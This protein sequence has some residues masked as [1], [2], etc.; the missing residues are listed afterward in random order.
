MN[1]C[2]VAL[3]GC[4]TVGLG[5]AE[6]L[7]GR[8]GAL[9]QRLGSGVELKYIIDVRLEELRSELEP[10]GG[11]MLTDDLQ[12]PLSDSDVDVVVE[13]FGGKDIAREVVEDALKAGKDV[14]TA[15]KALLAAHGAELYQLA[16]DKGGSIAFEASV[17]GGIP[18]VGAMGE[19]LVS[20]RVESVHGIVNGTC[21]YIL[22]RMTEQGMSFEDAL[23]E[24]QEKGY[25]EADP[26]LD[27]EG[28]DSAHKLAVLARLA[29]GIDVGEE[30]IYCEGLTEVE[31]EDICYARSLGYTV[32]LLAIGISRAGR[33]ELR[34]HPAL[35]PHEHPLAAV[36]GARNAVCVRG[37][38]VGE[39]VLTGLGAG[40]WPTASAVVGDIS[41][42]ALGT[43]QRQFA[44]LSQFGDVPAAEVLPRGEVET[45]YYF[46][47]SCDDR[48]GV[49]AQVA[50]ILGEHEI[51]IASCIQQGQTPDESGRVPVVFLSHRAR[52]GAMKC[53][54][55]EIERLEAVEGTKT[56]MLRVEDI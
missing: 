6:I 24:A 19:S 36:D 25:A 49:L 10:P 42:M 16:R 45:R 29:F 37:D 44:A 20:E 47:L 22:T 46:R 35:L 51:S 8:R 1:K 21:N 28:S 54:L 14:V 7:L 38:S 5:V 39:V 2:G 32:K 43:Y 3:Y 33:Q 4:G 26:T 40:R 48:P 30:D 31:A 17:G 41:R 12:A 27:I 56:R 55:Q 50:G 23:E 9:A 53:A 11:V 18:V 34:V 15:N 13:L 52:E